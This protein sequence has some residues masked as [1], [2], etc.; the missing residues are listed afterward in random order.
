MLFGVSG[1]VLLFGGR[2]DRR[3][4]ALGA[5]F[6]IIASAF[7][8]PL[9]VRIEGTGWFYQGLR[10]ATVDAFVATALWR[11]A[12]AFPKV[13][14]SRTTRRVGTMCVTWTGV[15]GVALVAANL[16]RSFS[17]W[18]EF[19]FMAR[20]LPVLSRGTPHSAYWFLTLGTAIFA[21]PYL[22]WKSRLE[23]P[24]EQPRVR[25]LFL[26]L[27]VGIAPFVLA[28]LA[29]IPFPVLGQH[30]WQ[31]LIGVALYAALASTIPA[32]AYAVLVDR[33][34]DIHLT[35]ARD[36][37]WQ[38]AKYG[39]W[40]AS[41]APFVYVAADLHVH[42]NVTLAAYL[43]DGRAVGLFLLL[44]A[45]FSALTFRHEILSIVE[46]WFGA[47]R[48]DHA[49]VLARL[50]RSLRSTRTIRDAADSLVRALGAIHPASSTVLVVNEEGDRLLPVTGAVSPLGAASVLVDLIRSAGPDMRFRLS[51]GSPLL[52]L[53]PTSDR[54]WLSS[55]RVELMAPLL[56]SSGSLFG[57]VALGSARHG[58]PYSDQ[59]HA[60]VRSMCAQVAIRL[61]N[62]WLRDQPSRASRRPS[63]ADGLA[64]DWQDEPAECCPRCSLVWPAATK[65]CACGA[66]TEAA[67]LPLMVAGKFRLERHL[68][69]GGMGVVYLATDVS[70]GRRV[71]LKTLPCVSD[72]LAT[73]LQREAR[74]MATV[75]HPNL[76]QIYAAEQW[77]GSPVL[78]VEYLDGGTLLDSLRRAPFTVQE[79][80]GLGILLADVLDRLH[81]AGILHRDVKPSNIG[82][83]LTGTPKLLDLGLAAMS[84]E[85]A[86][87]SGGTTSSVVTAALPSAA[88]GLGAGS[89]SRQLFGTLRYMAPEALSG[90]SPTPSFDLW[91]L[92]LVLYESLTGHHPLGSEPGYRLPTRVDYVEF[93][94]VRDFCRDCPAPV[95]A[96]FRD[97]LSSSPERRPGT[98]REFRRALQLLQ[99]RSSPE[100]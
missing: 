87:E 39:V 72:A 91:A 41:L 2:R 79:T 19:S 15:V 50:E 97:T 11:F 52:S 99:G 25:F 31:P 92:G 76:A 20:L 80:L 36:R 10:A 30:P 40:M 34:M 70:L 29:S 32:V 66:S 14:A 93:P 63:T 45:G 85:L 84:D 59:D 7:A 78:I 49:V 8:H 13:A 82:Y 35:V 61:E 43:A 83:T 38:I 24:E 54:A 81:G 69:A 27:V 18:D 22:A 56:N 77:R 60:L 58:L 12:W 48:A 64:L 65:L 26:A 94:D 5:V 96:F 28:V 47:D 57:V 37:Q 46:R 53:L 98:A 51:E 1:V 90:A 44:F 67:A 100:S 71:A 68:G 6:V 16:L 9:M 89:D 62:Q 95:A 55:R 86:G 23:T 17:Q 88:V 3:L 73:R 42:R 33:V 21:L 74:A 4:Q 75:L